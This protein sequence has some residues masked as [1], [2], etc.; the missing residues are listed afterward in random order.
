MLLT[1]VTNLKSSH[2]ALEFSFAGKDSTGKFGEVDI[3]SMGGIC[4]EYFGEGISLGLVLSRE[5]EDWGSLLEVE[6]EPHSY[7]FDIISLGV[8]A[9]SHSG[10]DVLHPVKKNCEAKSVKE[11]FCECSYS[12]EKLDYDINEKINEDSFKFGELNVPAIHLYPK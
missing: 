3:R 7:N 2:I 12:D 1:A 5:W 6:L 11:Y 9:Y 8:F 10:D 4:V